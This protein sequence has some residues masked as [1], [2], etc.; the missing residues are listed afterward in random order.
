MQTVFMMNEPVSLLD[1]GL[2]HLDKDLTEMFPSASARYDWKENKIRVF[3][4]VTEDRTDR[5][6]A[7]DDC[8]SVIAQLKKRLLPLGEDKSSAAF[9]LT[10]LSY[11]SHRDYQ[12]TREPKSFQDDVIAMI[13]VEAQAYFR[14][15]EQERSSI[16][17]KSSLKSPE[18]YC[19]ET[20][21]L[22]I[23]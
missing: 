4:L 18:V 12:S 8:K 20:A 15:K 16:A 19:A 3:V 17:C 2:D 1:Y 9:F 21:D 6:Q 23:Q 7:E 13:Q 11:F 10:P 14:V 22:A 5:K